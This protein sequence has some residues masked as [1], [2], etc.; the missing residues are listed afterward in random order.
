MQSGLEFIS[1]P[2]LTGSESLNQSPD[3]RT[4][5]NSFNDVHSI[6][7]LNHRRHGTDRRCLVL[8]S[9]RSMTLALADEWL[10]AD[11]G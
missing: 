1:S 3:L 7:I 2:L 9:L 11:Y 5:S 8:P 10:L 4:P 6:V